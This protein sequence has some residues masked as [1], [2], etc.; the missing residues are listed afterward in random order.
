MATDCVRS[1]RFRVQ[2]GPLSVTRSEF[3]MPQ[4]S[5]AK[6]RAVWADLTAGRR[7]SPSATWKR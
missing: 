6:L 2:Q 1:S 7:F 3:A 5:S 4:T